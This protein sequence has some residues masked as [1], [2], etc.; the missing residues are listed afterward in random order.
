MKPN[1]AIIHQLVS[2]Q[3]G[4]YIHDILGFEVSCDTGSAMI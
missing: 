2:S 4:Y 1:E 3:L